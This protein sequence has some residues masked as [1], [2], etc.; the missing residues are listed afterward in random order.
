[1]VQKYFF[2]FSII[3]VKLLIERGANANATRN[4]DKVSAIHYAVLNGLSD[5]VALLLLQN[6]DANAKARHIGDPSEEPPYLTP[7]LLA[8]EHHV[9]NAV[10]ISRQLLAHGA[11]VNAAYRAVQ[12]TPLHLAVRNGNSELVTLLL[13]HHADPNAKALYPDDYI[14]NSKGDKNI[15]Y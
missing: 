8:A 15:F 7:L 13:D 10:S 3:A 4:R 2:N 14:A 12:L 9:N 1:M 6:V 11:D 5:I